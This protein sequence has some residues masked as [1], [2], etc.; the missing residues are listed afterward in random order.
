[1]SFE[2]QELPDIIRVI[3]LLSLSKEAGLN[4][5]LLKRRI[6]KMCANYVCIEP[7]D[8]DK[9][10]NKMASERLI[11]SHDDVIQLTEQGL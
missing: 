5:S 1:M 10:L 8:L 6:D 11:L 3:V 9:A 7:N 2:I 4:K